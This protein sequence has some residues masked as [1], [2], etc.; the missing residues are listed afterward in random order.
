MASTDSIMDLLDAGM[1]AE[2]LRQ[3]AVASN[4]ANIETP[5]Y[6]RVDVKF[7]QFL[8]KALQSSDSLDLDDV[9]PQLYQPRQTATK[10]NG[11][12]VD[13][14]LEVGEMVKNSVRQKAFVRLLAK[15]YHQID[16]AI[17][18]GHA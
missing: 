13:L 6:R 3:K 2:G 1:R 9:E 5:G 11:N 8:A 17:D 10:S 4:V 7:E 16:L 15:K 14:E 18:T 12:D